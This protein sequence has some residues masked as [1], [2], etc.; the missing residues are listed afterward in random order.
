MG[1]SMRNADGASKAAS[2][3][4]A[5][6]YQRTQDSPAATSTPPTV[7]SAVAVRVN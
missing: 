5:D 1:R 3:R 7:Q 2:S 6:G 4:F